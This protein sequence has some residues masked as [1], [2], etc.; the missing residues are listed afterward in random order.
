MLENELNYLKAAK[1]IKNARS[2]VILAGAGMSAD[3]GIQTYED[4]Q[5]LVNAFPELEGEGITSYTEMAKAKWFKLKPNMA[6][7]FADHSEKSFLEAEPHKGY[8]IIRS[9]LD[10]KHT[11]FTVTTNVDG[12]F[13]RSGFNQILEIHG[14]HF[15]L[16]CTDN[17]RNSIWPIESNRSELPTCPQCGL[18]A[19]PNVLYFEDH[20]FCPERYEIQLE[21]YRQFMEHATLR[22]PLAIEIGAGTLL[23]TLRHESLKF[24]HVIRINPDPD[25]N[26]SNDNTIH[27][28][29]N[30]LEAL[31]RLNELI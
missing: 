11:S 24:D 5:A 28:Q 12:A 27:I 23:P 4:P 15:Q 19:R 30:A 10:T 22:T 16:Q 7:L 31:R 14:N 2:I 26:F 25:D 6:W 3:S 29:K 13:I 21:Q 20:D 17:C 9:W 8:Q 1:L 18:I